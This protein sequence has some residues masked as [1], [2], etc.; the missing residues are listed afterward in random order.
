MNVLSE[1]MIDN[2]LS[3]SFADVQ[4]YDNNID[5]YLTKF[6]SPLSVIA[7]LLPFLH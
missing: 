7:L 3:E 5:L 4:L 2:V 1:D 6:V